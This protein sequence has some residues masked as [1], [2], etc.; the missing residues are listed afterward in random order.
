MTYLKCECSYRRTDS[1]CRDDV[2]RVLDLN[3]PLFG[4]G[5]Q[6]PGWR[7]SPERDLSPTSNISPC[8]TLEVRRVHVR[9]LRQRPPRQPLARVVHRLQSRPLH[10]NENIKSTVRRPESYRKQSTISGLPIVYLYKCK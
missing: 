1:V 5:S 6:V 3:I 9:R 8:L 7:N 4:Y 2:R 10:S